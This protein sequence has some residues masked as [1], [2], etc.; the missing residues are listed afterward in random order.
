M[1]LFILAPPTI[2]SS[3]EDVTMYTGDSISIPCTADGTPAPTI[4]YC[5]NTDVLS[6][7]GGSLTNVNVD[8]SGAYQCFA[9]N[10]HG[11]VSASWTITV[12]DPG[13]CASVI[14]G[15]TYHSTV[16]PMIVNMSGGGTV[17]Q[18]G[19]LLIFIEVSAGPMPSVDWQLEGVSLNSSDRRMLSMR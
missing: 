9:E 15:F 5:F 8:N 19:D 3:P 6:V 2:S 18:D 16:A 13:E 12:R 4:S 1:L 7:T 14:A 10:I 11:V 17:P